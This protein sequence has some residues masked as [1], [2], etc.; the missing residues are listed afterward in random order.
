MNR[1]RIALWCSIAFIGMSV[2]WNGRGGAD[3]G[4]THG[5]KL[6]A[7]PVRERHELMEEIGS[8]AEQ[9]GN[10]IK[11]G[12]TDGVADHAAAIHER[13]Q[14]VVELFE[15]KA[16]H[17]ESRAK[18]EIWSNWEWF[19]RDSRAFVASSGKL[20]EA[21]RQNDDIRGAAGEMFESCKTCHK[22]FR[23]PEK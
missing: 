2:G 4:H 22:E 9:I 3:E 20:L 14:R 16:T 10:K 5:E 21:A 17:P 1:S 6:P 15:E 8:H 7:G 19:E 11:S 13:A 18:E 12:A 23:E